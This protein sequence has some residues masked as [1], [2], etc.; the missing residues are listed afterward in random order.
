MYQ[1]KKQISE[2]LER[3]IVKYLGTIKNTVILVTTTTT[4][5]YYEKKDPD[6]SF[7]K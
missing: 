6:F 5:L 7:S 2:Q 4:L 3:I 1:E